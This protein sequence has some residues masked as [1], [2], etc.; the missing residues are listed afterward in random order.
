MP[1]L[2]DVLS[3]ESYNRLYERAQMSLMQIEE[4]GNE[5]VKGDN[6]VEGGKFL[7]PYANHH[8]G[9]EV[10]YPILRWVH[11]ELYR[12]ARRVPGL[13]EGYQAL[14][15]GKS[16]LSI[17]RSL[18]SGD[19]VTWNDQ[20]SQRL[21]SQIALLLR[22]N[23]LAKKRHNS[24][25]STEWLVNPWHEP[26]WVGTGTIVKPDYKVEQRIAE[27]AEKNKEVVRRFDPAVLGVPEPT[28]D[29]FVAWAEKVKG[30]IDRLNGQYEASLVEAKKLREQ[31]E[32]LQ[33]ALES[34][35]EDPW[36]MAQARLAELFSNPGANNG[37]TQE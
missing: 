33:A 35:K 16:L 29:G 11:S 27:E 21:S 25:R 4:I 30:F 14:S 26:Q 12:H 32:Q 18:N 34:V 3:Q 13:E 6:R 37:E 20:Q 2:A 5:L 28:P 1:K 23:R 31:N 36:E 17:V 24:G 10:S 15:K 22:S 19:V 9:Q 8:E 7:L